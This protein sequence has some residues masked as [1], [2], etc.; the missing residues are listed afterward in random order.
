MYYTYIQVYIPEEFCVEFAQ[1]MFSSK[2]IL[3]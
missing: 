3:Y 2:T 1:I